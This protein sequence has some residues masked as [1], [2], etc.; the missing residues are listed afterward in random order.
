[1]TQKRQ[2]KGFRSERGAA[3]LIAVFALLLIS[4][5]G[6]A[7]IVSSGTD[8]ALARNYRTSTNAYYAALAGI[9][10]ARARLLPTNANYIPLPATPM[11]LTQVVYIINP[12]AGETVA[13]D[14]TSNP[15]TYP[16]TQYKQEFGVDVSTQVVTKYNSVSAVAGL[17]GPSFKWVR[18]NAV[19]EKS[20]GNG[21]PGVDV[22]NDGDKKA[23]VPLYFDSVNQTVANVPSPGL[24]E[25]TNPPY[26]A[27]QV[28]EVTAFAAL[29]SGGQKML[30]YIVRPLVVFPRLYFSS[31]DL[32]K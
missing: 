17:P 26:T 12:A 19:T 24:I 18:I 15:L 25:T 1:M 23:S 27:Q 32:A 5:V 30:Q 14:D 13:P 4:V 8:S 29:P 20:L 21:G 22:N 6:I 7:L 9:E 28:L 16:D 10:E 3:L 11:P 2:F 31:G